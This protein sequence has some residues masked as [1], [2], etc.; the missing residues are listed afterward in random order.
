MIGSRATCKR[1]TPAVAFRNLRQTAPRSVAAYAAEVGTADEAENSMVYADGGAAEEP[2]AAPS[3]EASAVA[4]NGGLP[5]YVLN[6]IWLDKAIG[7]AVDQH[8][9][10][11]E[12]GPVTEYFMWPANDAWEQLKTALDSMPWISQV[13]VIHLLNDATE[14]INYWQDESAKHT[15]EEARQN[16]PHITFYG[17]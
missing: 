2:A 13:E 12:K 1:V 11:A 8:L 10:S 9:A 14:V 17:S 5:S 6:I 4:D 16:F 7:V 15:I 3:P